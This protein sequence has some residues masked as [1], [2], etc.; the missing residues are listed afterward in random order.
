[1]REDVPDVANL[2]GIPVGTGMLCSPQSSKVL[3]ILCKG[4]LDPP[5]RKVFDERL[6]MTRVSCIWVLS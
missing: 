5:N 1:M 4:V 2:H 3:Q 6:G